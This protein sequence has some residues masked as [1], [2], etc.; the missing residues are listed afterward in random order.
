MTFLLRL[1]NAK[2]HQLKRSTLW[3]YA[4]GKY[5]EFRGP[6][7]V[8]TYYIL[9]ELCSKVLQSHIPTWEPLHTQNDLSCWQK[10]KPQDHAESFLCDKPTKSS[11]LLVVPCI[12]HFKQ[13][14]LRNITSASNSEFI[15]IITTVLSR[16]QKRHNEEEGLKIYGALLDLKSASNPR[17]NDLLKKYITYKNQS[18]KLMPMTLIGSF[19]PNELICL[20]IVLVNQ[21]TF[22]AHVPEQSDTI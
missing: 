10:W 20:S 2:T 17:T 22:Y 1:A 4:G 15:S 16:P 12:V 13:G 3:S 8:L 19:G 9:Q 21:S 18:P 7:F 6:S 11:L 14:E 5:S